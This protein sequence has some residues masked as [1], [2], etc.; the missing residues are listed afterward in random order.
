[1]V[2]MQLSKMC[3]FSWTPAMI[4][5]D[6]YLNDIYQGVYTFS[7]HKKVSSERVNINTDQGDFYFEI[8]QFQDNPVSWNTS[9]YKIPLMFD[10]PEEPGKDAIAEGK[11]VFS[12][13]EQALSAESFADPDKGYAAHIDVESFI[14]NYIVQEL[15]KNIDGDLRKST[16][17]TKTVGGKLEMYHIWD[18]DLALGNCDYFAS[19]VGMPISNGYS[20]WYVRDFS[21]AGYQ[22]G[23]YYRLFQDPAFVGKV[24]DKW[25]RLYPLFKIG[26]PEFIESQYSMMEASAD[27]NFVTWDILSSYVWPNVVVTGSYRSEVN[28]L[29]NFFLQRLEWMNSE[30]SNM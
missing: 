28:Y 6:I 30:F 11:K 14:N 25:N 24:I 5:V 20:G 16:F 26:I 17:L 8:E 1:M 29:K 18:F 22:T 7:E 23:W 27:D 9:I 19:E 4:S 13:F 10:D 21:H 15:T 3:R 2:A 12:D